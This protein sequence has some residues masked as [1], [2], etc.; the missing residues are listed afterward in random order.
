MILR[1]YELLL[2]PKMDES[3]NA[4]GQRTTLSILDPIATSCPF[5]LPASAQQ[6]RQRPSLPPR[7]PASCVCDEPSRAIA[8]CSSRSHRLR[9]PPPR[10]LRAR[11]RRRA[12]GSRS[13]SWKSRTSRVPSRSPRRPMWSCRRGRLP[14]MSVLTR[15]GDRVEVLDGDGWL[16]RSG[17]GGVDGLL[18][19]ESFGSSVLE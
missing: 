5:P 16:E 17:S 10:Q 14:P 18:L 8:S 7:T 4:K 12:V 11:R 15:R 1:A 3:Y 6:P 9:C 19:P 13:K 2:Q